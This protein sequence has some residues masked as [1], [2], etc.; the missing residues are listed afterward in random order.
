MIFNCLGC[1]TSVS[2]NRLKCPYCKTNN[3]EV[4][5][6]LTGIAPKVERD[7]WRERVKG[8]IFSYVHR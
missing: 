2:T 6:V 7:Q 3:A 8:T 1:G 5:E 4:V